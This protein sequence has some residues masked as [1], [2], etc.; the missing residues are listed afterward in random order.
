MYM[1]LKKTLFTIMGLALTLGLLASLVIAAVPVSA[2]V[3]QPVVVITAST[4]S[5]AGNYIITFD[6]FFPLTAGTDTITVT[7]PVGTT[8]PATFAGGDVQVSNDANAA[9]PTWTTA[10]TAVGDATFRTVVITVSTGEGNIG[11]AHMGV[12][13]LT[14]D[15]T[16]DGAGHPAVNPGT[17]GSFTL[18]VKTSQETTAVESLAYTITSGPGPEPG[19]EVGGEVYPNTSVAILVFAVLT[20]ALLSGAGIIIRRR[21]IQR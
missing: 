15:T 1:A 6:T 20:I 11:P 17:P 12:K 18:T 19:P 8:V 4:I 7:F 21:L 16:P 2:A 10:T 14:A 3:S 9:T 13:F 5:S